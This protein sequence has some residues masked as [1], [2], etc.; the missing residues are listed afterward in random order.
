MV[1][2]FGGYPYPLIP[3]KDSKPEKLVERWILFGSFLGC[4]R[5]QTVRISKRC[6][7]VGLAVTPMRGTPG[8]PAGAFA[9][10]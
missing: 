7:P 9:P 10:G 6:D 3:V 1:T 5:I 4:S 8:T 2:W